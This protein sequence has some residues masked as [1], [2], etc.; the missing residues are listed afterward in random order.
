MR[1]CLIHRPG[2]RSQPCG[3]KLFLWAKPHST[4][5]ILPFSLEMKSQMQFCYQH[6][7]N[8]SQLSFQGSCCFLPYI[9]STF[10]HAWEKTITPI[11]GNNDLLYGSRWAAGQLPDTL[12]R[13]YYGVWCL[14]QGQLGV[15]P[16]VDCH[17]RRLC[18]LSYCYQSDVTSSMWITGLT[19]HQIRLIGCK[20]VQ[21]RAKGNK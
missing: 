11:V 21:Q 18:H 6:L 3:T 8:I 5:D 17:R 19:Q 20:P 4:S 7:C 10:L 12:W 16:G 9:Y 13:R 2:L 14:V 15:W 1:S